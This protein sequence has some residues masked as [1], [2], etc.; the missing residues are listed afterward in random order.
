MLASLTRILLL[1][2][3]SIALSKVHADV[4][5]PSIFG[6][7]MVLQRNHANPVWGWANPGEKVVITIA[8]QSHATKADSNGDWKIALEP[9]PAGGPHSMVIKGENSLSYADILVGEVWICSGQSNMQWPVSNSYDGDLVAATANS[10]QIRLISVPQVGTQEPQKDF[11]GQWERCST[12]TVSNFSAIGYRFGLQLQQALGVPIGLIDN[13]WGGSSAEAWV[14]RD[15]LESDRRYAQLIANWEKTESEFDIEK[16]TADYQTKLNTWTANGKDGQRPRAPRNP[17]TGNHRPA[18]IYNGVLHPTI[19]YGIKGAIWYQGESN[20]SRAY[21]YRHLFPLMIQH[22]RDE[23]GQGDFPFYYVQL[24]DFKEMVSEP[25]D[26]DWAELREA[27]TMTMDALDNTGQAVIIDV[28]EGRDIHPRDKHTV[29][30]RLAR[31]ALAKDYGIDIV[32]QSPNYKSMKVKGSKVTLTFDHVGQGLYS[33]D[34]REP[35]GFSIAGK[36]ETF[37][38]AQARIVDANTIEVWS[39]SIDKPA[40]VRYAW[41]NNPQCNLF[42]R[43]GLP[44]TPFRTDDWP[45]VTVDNHK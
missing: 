43:D 16:E 32:H 19:G 36:D 11:D 22:W 21:Q 30:N 29:A 37:V 34:T 12:K 1:A 14:R 18:N 41:A 3:V 33:F 26:S 45:G 40:A 5:T 9:L 4:S 2:T 20:A 6:D 31:W 24:A 15:I 38:W 7:H 13:A 17:L 25:G 44:A 39:D 23:W 27:Q 10:S 35:T 42:S 28:G 8:G